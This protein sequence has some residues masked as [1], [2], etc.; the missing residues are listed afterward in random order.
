MAKNVNFKDV[1]YQA[2]FGMMTKVKLP[3]PE[4]FNN[5]NDDEK[6]ALYSCIFDR[7]HDVSDFLYNFLTNDD[8]LNKYG[9]D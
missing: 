5:L 6:L 7:W 3:T 1:A 8:L 4:A 2:R 9:D